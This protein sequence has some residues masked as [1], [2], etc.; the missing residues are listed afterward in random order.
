[1]NRKIERERNGFGLWI[2]ME[3]RKKAEFFP[4]KVVIAECWVE[5]E[6]GR[7]KKVEESLCW[8]LTC[9]RCRAHQISHFFSFTLHLTIS[10][11]FFFSIPT[12]TPYLHFCHHRFPSSFGLPRLPNRHPKKLCV[13]FFSLGFSALPLDTWYQTLGEKN[14]ILFLP[15]GKNIY[16]LYIFNIIFPR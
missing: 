3:G 15:I 1:M 12:Y 13:F 14:Y 16:Y 7:S 2:M 11:V 9:R 5:V 10:F 6:G 4:K 8:L